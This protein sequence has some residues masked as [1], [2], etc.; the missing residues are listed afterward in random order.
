MK[1]NIK[2]FASVLTMIALLA[3]G[4]GGSGG[5]SS[6]NNAPAV[7]TNDDGSVGNHPSLTPTGEYPVVKP[8]ET[9]E[10]EMF[11]QLRAGVTSYEVA[12]NDCSKWLADTTGITFKYNPV[13]SSDRVV[14]QNTL[15]TSG[16][17]PDV[18]LDSFFSASELLLYGQQ[19]VLIPLNDLIENYAPNIKKVL[20]ANP[21]IVKELTMED[22]NI[23][24]LPSVGGNVHGS[25]AYKMWIN[26]TWLDNL[27]LPM[28]TTVE[29]LK[30][31]LIAFRDQ[32]PN[33]NG[34][35]DEIPMSGSLNGWNTD[36]TVFIANAFGYFEPSKSK[37]FR[38]EDGKVVHVKETEG[39]KQTLEYMADLYSEGLLDNLFLSQTADELKKTADSPG[40]S[41]VG[42][43]GGGSSASFLTI[44]ASDRWKEY[45]TLP[46]LKGATE[47]GG[48][49]AT[50]DIHQNSVLNIT[51]K[52]ENPEA[53]I[54]AFDLMYTMEGLTH[55]T[56]GVE[57]TDWRESTADELN[58]EGDPA[59][60]TMLTNSSERGNRVWNQLGPWYRPDNYDL[61]MVADPE[62]IE[63]LLYNDSVE[64]Y[65]P[66]KAS[67]DMMMPSLAFT[68]EQSRIA[69]DVETPLNSHND[70]YRTAV[71]TGKSDTASTWDAYIKTAQDL[72]VDKYTEIYQVAYDIY[73][74]N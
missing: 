38:V 14:R 3:T 61:L 18:L 17:Y 62:S 25:V 16:T 32:D 11:T 39:W 1:K 24:S 54:R 68:Q 21:D 50:L 47:D 42:V 70:E 73:N 15:M 7:T 45:V 72:G 74:S 66:A 52:C 65:V 4:C 5:G 10:I 57:G 12:D 6:A 43:C 35:K 53:V 20:D 63:T 34:I 26:Q 22:G 58:Y 56:F 41:M 31:T 64:H 33:G 9:V 13:T 8:G 23:Y 67:R 40:V 46:P 30:T 37:G 28:P 19:G 59:T 55:N 27:N 49:T 51:N 36:P 44:G 60:Y 2:I 71:I 48:Y 29:E 69:I